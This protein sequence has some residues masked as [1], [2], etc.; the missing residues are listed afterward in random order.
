MLLR[1]MRG[2]N[3]D[4]PFTRH[5]ACRRRLAASFANRDIERVMPI[6]PQSPA[7]WVK[8]ND[9]FLAHLLAERAH[10]WRTRTQTQGDEGK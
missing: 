8:E 4:T 2:G 7:R 9:K 10:E 1:A 6:I 3:S 5:L